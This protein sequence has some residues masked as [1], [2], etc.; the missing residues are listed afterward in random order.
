MEQYLELVPDRALGEETGDM[1]AYTSDPGYDGGDETLLKADDIR[2]VR[3]LLPH[4]TYH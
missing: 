2:K 3:S 1:L 4:G